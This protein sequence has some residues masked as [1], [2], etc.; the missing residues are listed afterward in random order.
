MMRKQAYFG[1][2][3]LFL[4]LLG[5]LAAAFWI[6]PDR[7]FSEQENRSLQGLPRL[8]A[9]ALLSGRYADAVNDYFADQFPMRDSLVA[10]K[11]LCE[12]ARGMGENDGILLGRDGHL[13]RGRFEMRDVG[14]ALLT[15]TDYFDPAR[16]ALA[17]ERLSELSE[18]LGCSFTV[19][20]VGRAIDI[21]AASFDYP[22]CLSERL[23]SLF[24]AE[25]A[26]TLS[27]VDVTDILRERHAA[28]EYVY[29]R[30]DHHWT[31]RG[32]YYAYA[33]LMREMGMEEEILPQDAFQIRTVEDFYG[34]AWSAGGMKFVP[35]DALEIWTLGDEGEYLVVADGRELDGFYAEGYL[36]KKDKYSVF[37]DG[38]HDVVTVTRRDGAERPTLLILRDSYAS[39]IAPFLARHFDLVLL[40]LSSTRTDFTDLS[41]LVVQ[42]RPDRAVLI[43]G[44]ENILTA[45]KVTRLH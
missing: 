4:A 15:D 44:M 38:T 10:L 41:G 17:T 18:S 3:A 16:V 20:A 1:T 29:Y 9:E 24:D 21:C 31:T 25:L 42:Y 11:G 22:S 37:L 19:M 28:G 5:I 35:P 40:N 23:L 33:A 27:R 26:D 30:T 6:L 43:Y 13:A 14:G 32:A 8:D 36:A 39:S 7:E 2:V 12:L 45:D 34:T